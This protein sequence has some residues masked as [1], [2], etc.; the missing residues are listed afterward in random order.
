MVFKPLNQKKKLMAYY[1]VLSVYLFLTSFP[2]SLLRAVTQYLIYE[3]LKLKQ[4]PYTRLDALS[5][6]FIGLFF[7]N[8]YLIY[9]LGFILS[10]IISLFFCL[11]TARKRVLWLIQTH[12]FCAVIGDT[13]HLDFSRSN[14]SNQL[15]G[16]A[17]IHGL[18]FICDTTLILG[19]FI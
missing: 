4:K 12:A 18:F 6:S 14:I 15:F 8:P 17:N 13:F 11:R 10:F 3:T 1:V 7:F 2:V 19:E 5:L 16:C 9:Q